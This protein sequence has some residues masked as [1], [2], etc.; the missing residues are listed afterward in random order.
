MIWGRRKD[1]QSYKKTSSSRTK[2]S[3][4]IKAGGKKTI[5]LKLGDW[6][7]RHPEAPRKEE[8][9][10]VLVI[11]GAKLSFGHDYHKMMNVVGDLLEH[12]KNVKIIRDG[13]DFHFSDDD[14]WHKTYSGNIES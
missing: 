6:E 4:T 12:K 14:E 7:K 9:N 11:D 1:G 2:K 13:Y 5:F 10:W 3:G 8:S